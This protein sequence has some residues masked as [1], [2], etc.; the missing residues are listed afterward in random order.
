MPENYQLSWTDSKGQGRKSIYPDE[1]WWKMIRK[2]NVAVFYI[3]SENEVEIP[4]YIR[5]GK[6]M[7]K[8]KINYHQIEASQKDKGRYLTDLI[9]RA[10]DIPDTVTLSSYEKLP[11]PN[12]IY[13]KDTAFRGNAWELHTELFQ[14]PFIPMGCK[15]YANEVKS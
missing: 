11:V 9:L 3:L 10:E 12:S 14:K 13:L 15:F 1:G 4:Q 6:F 7:S 2:G 5:L 8:C